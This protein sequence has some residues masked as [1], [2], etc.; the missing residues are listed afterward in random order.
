MLID[1]DNLGMGVNPPLVGKVADSTAPL[2]KLYDGFEVL[3]SFETGTLRVQA[4]VKFADGDLDCYGDSRD[5]IVKPAPVHFM[6]RLPYN[7][8][9]GTPIYQNNPNGPFR[10]HWGNGIG[11]TG[12]T[13]HS[14]PEHRYSYDIGVFDKNNLTFLDPAKRDKNEN[15]YCWGQDVIAMLAGD[16]MFIANDFEDNFGNVG[17]PNSKGANLVVL[18]NKA[19]DVFHI[20]AHFQKGSIVVAVGSSVN[21]GDKLGLVGNSGGS[22]EPHLHVGLNQRDV[23]GFLRSLPMSFTKIKNGAGQTVSGVPVDNEFYS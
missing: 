8:P 18:H 13:A 20:Y 17:N 10:W 19:S 15:Y 11:G 14:Y 23:N 3:S 22:G 9:G 12:F 7:K 5:L 16:V 21:A 1:Q 6:T 2:A 4:N